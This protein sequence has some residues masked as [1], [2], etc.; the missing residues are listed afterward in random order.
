M[1]LVSKYPTIVNKYP[2][3]L[4]LPNYQKT[5]G[6]WLKGRMADDGAEGL[7][8]I[9]DKL[10]DFNAYA[11]EHPGGKEWLTMTKVRN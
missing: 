4:K 6:N 2:T 5:C 1:E 11:D 8:R 3:F 10:Y 7:W 9:H